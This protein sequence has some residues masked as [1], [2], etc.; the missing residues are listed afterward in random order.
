MFLGRLIQINCL[1][2][3]NTLNPANIDPSSISV[4]FYA[5][6]HGP[7]WDVAFNREIATIAR[8]V[9]KH[10]AGIIGAVCHGTCGLLPITLKA[11][12]KPTLLEN[13]KVT[14]FTNDEEEMV[15]NE[16]T[17]NIMN[18]KLETKLTEAGAEFVKGE[19]FACNVVN[20]KGIVTGQNP[21]SSTK[22]AQVIVEELAAKIANKDAF[23]KLL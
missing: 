8:Q 21:Q 7:M 19:P 14:S 13:R 9:Y 6:G 16:D 17:W 11:A 1:I 5:G 20:H 23:N 10:N 22:C 15:F 4:V 18:F 12:T 3:D 2:S